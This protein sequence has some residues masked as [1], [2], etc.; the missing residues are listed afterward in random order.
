MTALVMM[1][2]PFPMWPVYLAAF[3]LFVFALVVMQ[4]DEPA[5]RRLT[6]A[7]LF[8]VGFA[9]VGPWVSTGLAAAVGDGI[10]RLMPWLLECWLF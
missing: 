1:S 3:L 9:F 2:S 10:C 6:A 8:S 4:Q 7:V 5:R